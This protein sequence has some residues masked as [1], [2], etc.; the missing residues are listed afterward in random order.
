MA[1]TPLQ[2]QHLQ[3]A[4]TNSS[5]RASVNQGKPA[6]VATSRPTV[7][8]GPGIVTT[9]KVVAPYHRPADAPMVKPAGQGGTAN[10]ATIAPTQ[11]MTGA[12]SRPNRPPQTGRS[13]YP[14][15]GTGSRPNASRTGPTAEPGALG[16]SIHPMAQPKPSSRPHSALPGSLPPA[17]A[18]RF[19]GSAH[20]QAHTHQPTGPTDGPPAAGASGQRHPASRPHQWS[21]PRPQ[22]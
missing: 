18:P 20:G 11:P 15:T 14:P 10:P 3:L 8:K 22:P 21:D 9:A 1:P 2:T 12:P 7:F 5:L 17:H 13:P 4:R 16:A 6:I 19:A